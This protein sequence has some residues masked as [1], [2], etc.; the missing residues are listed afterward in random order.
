M[1][2]SYRSRDDI[3]VDILA[4]I[5]SGA[6]KTHVM[7]RANLNPMMFRKYFP[8]LLENGLVVKKDDPDGGF[9][10]GLSGEGRELLKMYRDIRARFDMNNNKKPVHVLGLEG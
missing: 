7:Q 8:T 2:R 3:V 4:A 10:Y 6:K 9:L 5:S 1:V